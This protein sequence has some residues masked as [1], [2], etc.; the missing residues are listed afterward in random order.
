VKTSMT[1]PGSD[2]SDY[3]FFPSNNYM[4]PPCLEGGHLPFDTCI[5]FSDVSYAD[6]DAFMSSLTV[7]EDS[8]NCLP[9]PPLLLPI[10]TCAHFLD[11][12]NAE[13]S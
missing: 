8:D 13:F 1:L 5:D 4:H 11:L 12:S 3:E 7:N 2:N 9:L 10:G 6:L